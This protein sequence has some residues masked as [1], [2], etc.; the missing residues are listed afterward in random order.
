MVDSKVNTL[1]LQTDSER[2]GDHHHHHPPVLLQ[3][4]DLNKNGPLRSLYLNA[5]SPVGRTLGKGSEDMALLEEMGHW[6]QALRFQ[7]PGAIPVILSCGPVFMDQD[8]H[9]QFNPVPCL[10]A[11]MFPATMVKPHLL[12]L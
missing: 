12:K 5:W 2:D 3:T 10:S 1:F 4:L 6:G 11:A 8:V 9:S 7:K